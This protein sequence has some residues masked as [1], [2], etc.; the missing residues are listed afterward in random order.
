MRSNFEKIGKKVALNKVRQTDRGL[1][2]TQNLNTQKNLTKK[3]H[4]RQ[5]TTGNRRKQFT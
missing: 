5:N 2:Q 1:L 4:N 3:A